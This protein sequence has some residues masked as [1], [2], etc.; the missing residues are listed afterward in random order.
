V[1]YALVTKED[2]PAH[3]FV[4]DAVWTSMEAVVTHQKQSGGIYF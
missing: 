4:T 1:A 2:G 3:N